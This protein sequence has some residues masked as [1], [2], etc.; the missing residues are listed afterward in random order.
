VRGIERCGDGSGADP[1]RLAD[2]RVVEV[3]VV[4]EKDGGTL[5]LRQARE[6]Y[7]QLGIPLR[8]PVCKSPV[9]VGVPSD[10]GKGADRAGRSWIGRGWGA[11]LGVSK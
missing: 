5:P 4:A 8:M 2:R 1:E 11:T 10:V 9:G 6:R 3:R 7:A